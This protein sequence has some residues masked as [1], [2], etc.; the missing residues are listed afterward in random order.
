MAILLVRLRGQKVGRP[1]SVVCFDSNAVEM[2]TAEH[3]TYLMKFCGLLACQ[4]YCA[5]KFMFGTYTFVYLII[6]TSTSQIDKSWSLHDSDPDPT[7]TGTWITQNQKDRRNRKLN[8]TVIHSH[9][10]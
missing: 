4:C 8:P 5:L 10:P 3:S 6:L 7:R 1:V 2:T 9:S